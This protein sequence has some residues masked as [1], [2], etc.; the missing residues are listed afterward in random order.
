MS[1]H[2][3][4]KY[5]LDLELSKLEHFLK[6]NNIWFR[7]NFL[8]KYETYY[9]TGGNV[10]IFC[11]PNNLIDFRETINY[12]RA[13]EIDFK[14]VGYTSNTLFFDEI[15]YSVILSTKNLIN[16]KIEDEIIEVETGYYLY[17]FVRITSILNQAKGFEGLEGIP[18]SIGGAIFMNAAAYND[19]ISD[20]LIDVKLLDDNQQTIN[21][22]KEECKFKYRDSIFKS[23]NNYI[24]LSA[25]FKLVKGDIDNIAKKIE[26]V[27]IARHSYQEFVFPNLGSMISINKD[28]YLEILGADK[29]NKLKYYLLQILL[30]NKFVKFLKRKK[31][32][33]VGLNNLI[34]SKLGEPPNKM[35]KKS[36][37]ILLNSKDSNSL[38]ILNYINYIKIN[39][40]K[41]YKQEN[42]IVISP[43]YEIEKN[44]EQVLKNLNTH[45]NDN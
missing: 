42:E 4:T 12:L 31:P 37:N 27:H 8:L 6:T 25:R 20:N 44:F 32:D 13:R 10:K 35:S 22:N 33:N 5:N 19:S 29:I 24:I 21:L 23:N 43:A 11:S 45:K 30:K 26:A 28:I 14:I 2:H 38:S 17:D 9:K 16:V 15:E 39:I 40:D 18:G 34:I 36:V 3:Q 7:K 41:K 1:F